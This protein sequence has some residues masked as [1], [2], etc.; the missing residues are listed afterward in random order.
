M[1]RNIP[2]RCSQSEISALIASDARKFEV[3]MPRSSEKKCKGY[4]FI[5]VSE[6]QLMKRLVHDLWAK[7]VPSRRSQRPLKIHPAKLVT[8]QYQ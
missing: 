6:A 3:Q 7:C 2:A 4:A 1:I 5:Q 8:M